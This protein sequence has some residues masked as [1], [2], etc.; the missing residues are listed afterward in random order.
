MRA[1]QQRVPHRIGREVGA[2]DGLDEQV[3]LAG[4]RFVEQAGEQRRLRS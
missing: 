4:Q 1:A 3:G 2:A